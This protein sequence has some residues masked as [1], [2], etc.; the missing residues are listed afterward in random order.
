MRIEEEDKITCTRFD[1][2][3][4]TSIRLDWIIFHKCPWKGAECPAPSGS[5][6]AQLLWALNAIEDQLLYPHWPL[7]TQLVV[8]SSNRRP[9]AWNLITTLPGQYRSYHWWRWWWWWWL[10]DDH[11][12]QCWQWSSKVWS[13]SYS[14]W[15][16][17]WSTRR[18][19]IFVIG[20]GIDNKLYTYTYMQAHKN[21]HTCM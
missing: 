20:S 19:M 16:Q 2:F 21:V 13:E 15:V 18:V 1:N 6:G 5:G 12:K 17:C 7:A 11:K 8:K 4:A 14:W 10:S 3:L 9:A